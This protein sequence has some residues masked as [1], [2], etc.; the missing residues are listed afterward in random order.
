MRG[1]V[2]EGA[3]DQ[4]LDGP[5]GRQPLEVEAALLGADFLVDPFQHRK[6]KRVLVTEIVIHE[7]LVDTRTRGDF[8]D[9]RTGE[10][11]LC[12]FAPRRRQQFLA[13]SRRIAPLRR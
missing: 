1:E 10:A 4:L 6:V 7:L 5:F 3:L 2:I 11:A 9:P 8:V 12:K 13:C